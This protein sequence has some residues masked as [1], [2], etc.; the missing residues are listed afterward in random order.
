MQQ[1]HH[2]CLARS[3]YLTMTRDQK[4]DTHRPEY[5]K[6]MRKILVDNGAATTRE[7]WKH[8]LYVVFRLSWS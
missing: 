5:F 4:L 8:D 7:H 1:R 2:I 3:V 6:H